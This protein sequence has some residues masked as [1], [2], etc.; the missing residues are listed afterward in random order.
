MVT[1]TNALTARSGRAVPGS[2]RRGGRGKAE[3]FRQFCTHEALGKTY[4]TASDP[5]RM[6]TGASRFWQRAFRL[7]PYHVRTCTHRA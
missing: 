1:P 4:R 2:L 7:P 3:E 6:A 5:V